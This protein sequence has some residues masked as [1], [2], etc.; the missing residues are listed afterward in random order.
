MSS[1]YFLCL[2]SPRVFSWPTAWLVAW[3]PALP[4]THAVDLR[5]VG[6]DFLVNSSSRTVVSPTVWAKVHREGGAG[7]GGVGWEVGEGVSNKHARSNS[8]TFWLCCGQLWLLWPH[9]DRI[10][11]DCICRIWLPTFYLMLLFRRR[12]GSYC[13][14]LAQIQSGWPRQVLV[15]HQ[16]WFWQNA[17]SRLPVSHFQTHLFSS[18]DSPGHMGKKTARIQAGSG[19][20]CQ[21]L[22]KWIQ[23]GSK[24]V[25]KNHQAHFWANPGWMQIGSGMFTGLGGVGS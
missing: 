20:L 9:A 12:P 6:K 23:S 25:C 1:K 4:H 2:Q 18:T 7:W 3:L 21:V 19:R 11:L 10:G 22:A 24:L 13:A 16:A 14:K 15:N 8:E 17:I 5:S